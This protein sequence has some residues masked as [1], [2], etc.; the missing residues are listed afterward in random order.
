MASSI[1]PTSDP[2]DSPLRF[3]RIGNSWEGDKVTNTEARRLV[4]EVHKW[5]SQFHHEDV[6][7]LCAAMDDMDK[8]LIRVSTEIDESLSR[9]HLMAHQKDLQKADEHRKIAMEYLNRWQDRGGRAGN[10]G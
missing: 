1:I 6:K 3:K 8:A 10:A 4:A 2:I 5:A 7:S 9:L